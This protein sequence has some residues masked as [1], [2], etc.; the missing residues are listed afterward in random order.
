M[1]SYVL[2]IL[3]QAFVALILAYFSGTLVFRERRLYMLLVAVGFYLILGATLVEVWGDKAGWEA[4]AIGLNAALVATGVAAIG[5]GALLREAPSM[6]ASGLVDTVAKVFIGISAVMGVVLAS[7]GGT[8]EAIVDPTGILGIEISGGFS[9]LGNAGWALASP[10]FVGGLMMAWMGARG[11]MA[12]GD[13][14]GFWLMAAGVLF[15]LWPFDIQMAQLPLAPAFLMMALTMTYFGF[16]LPKEG[17]GDAEGEPEGEERDEPDGPAPWV[18]EA[19]AAS[20]EGSVDEGSDEREDLEG[21][22]EEE[23]PDEGDE[24]D[25]GAVEG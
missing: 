5:A 4:W 19:I 7:S 15:L 20:R 14:R 11:G 18:K 13:A 8:S 2:Y 12:R 17:E 10:F 23:D 16:Q 9:H 25:D 22:G 24:G 21:G 3:M 1:G 6:E